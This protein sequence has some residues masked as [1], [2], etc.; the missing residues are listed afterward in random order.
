VT[1]A[2]RTLPVPL[3]ARVMQVFV[4]RHCS[5]TAVVITANPVNA[6]AGAGRRKKLTLGRASFGISPGASWKARIKLSSKG[7][8]AVRKLELVKA[9][10]TVSAGNGIQ[11]ATKKF[12]V[13]LK[14]PGKR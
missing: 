2:S 7:M 8:R 4:L 3:S 14:S 9:V 12:G 1:P 13:R 6:K 5:G 11:T 10:V